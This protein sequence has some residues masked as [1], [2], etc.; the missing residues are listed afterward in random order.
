MAPKRKRA[1]A[2]ECME[3]QDTLDLISVL[4]KTSTSHD[5]QQRHTV[6]K[7]AC[8]LWDFFSAELRRAVVNADDRPL[9]HYYSCDGTPMRTHHRNRSTVKDIVVR[10]D[11]KATHEFLAQVVFLRY[12]DA[13][14]LCVDRVAFAPPLP[15]T[16]G[17]SA[18]AHFS[19]S[20]EFMSSV[21]A[22]GHK[23]ILVHQYCFDRALSSAMTRLLQQ[24]H[25]LE[26]PLYGASA[27]ESKYLARLE[28]VEG[29]GCSLHDAH[30]SL[31][32][33]MSF[34]RLGPDVMKNVWVVFASLRNSFD[35]ILL[36]LPQ[37]LVVHVAWTPRDQL[38]TPD[39]LSVLWQALQLDEEIVELLAQD[40]QLWWDRDATMLR[41]AE[42]WKCRP[43]A[44]QEL[45]A[46]LQAVWQFKKFSDSRWITIGC[47]CRTLTAAILTGLASLVDRIRTHTIG[48]ELHINGWT[49]LGKEETRFVVLSSM[50]AYVSDRALT[51]IFKDTRVA[52]RA[53]EISAEV[54]DSLERMEKLDEHV[55][56]SLALCH[57]PEWRVKGFAV[58]GEALSAAHASAG[59]FHWKCLR[60]TEQLPWTLGRGDVGANLVALKAG[61]KPA[62][63][64]ARKIW[65]LLQAGHSREQLETGVRLLMDAPWATSAT[66]QAHAMGA[67]VKRLHHELGHKAIIS[68][69][70]V[71]GFRKMFPKVSDHDAQMLKLRDDLV[72]N[73]A[74]VPSRCSARHML[75]GDAVQTAMA[76]ERPGGRPAGRKQRRIMKAHSGFF[77]KLSEEQRQGYEMA[78]EIHAREK[79]EQWSQEREDTLDR[80][81]EVRKKQAKEM[82]RRKPLTL[83]SCRLDAA[84]VQ[85][86]HNSWT[87]AHTSTESIRDRVAKLCEAP[88]WISQ[89][90]YEEM[91]A[92]PYHELD[93]MYNRAAQRPRWLA[94]VVAHR[95][96]FAN[97]VWVLQKGIT[98]EYY[99]FLLAQQ[100][101]HQILFIPLTRLDPAD[102]ERACGSVDEDVQLL[103]DYKWDLEVGQWRDWSSL[104][105]GAGCPV[106]VITQCRHIGNGEVVGMGDPPL[107]EDFLADLDPIPVTEPA[108]KKPKT[109][110]YK[111]KLTKSTIA[112]CPLIEED[113]HDAGIPLDAVAEEE[114]EEEETLD[115]LGMRLP[116]REFTDAE[117]VALWTRLEE[118][119]AE[120]DGL[121]YGKL[122]AGAFKVTFTKGE[123]TKKK[124]GRDFDF[125][126]AYAVN[127][128]SKQ[129]CTRYRMQDSARFAT[130]QYG[131]REATILAQGWCSRMDHFLSIYTT[132]EDPD[133]TF[134]AADTA[135]WDPPP[136]WQATYD[137]VPDRAKARV[138]EL[139]AK[140]PTRR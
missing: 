88:D 112:K 36:H 82:E 60:A 122:S 87:S 92:Q 140:E 85:R 22:M 83:S 7:L 106:R 41:V 130:G 10:R 28:W 26:A 75:F 84:G 17:K 32:W 76:M 34:E 6:Q 29:A 118:K 24:H 78:A 44:M 109:E 53:D 134:I 123:F 55:W 96:E 71:G 94:Q 46:A 73:A 49:K 110:G 27:T 19:A 93:W 51:M 119:R 67:L 86:L 47:S 57:K 68:R 20:L 132:S 127:K 135:S 107:L 62:Q 43:D 59:Y 133:Y 54:Q 37:W 4:G 90:R 128:P 13:P 39:K 99:K 3:G 120:W 104:G 11:G 65:E 74:H 9:L 56:E 102:E 116:D 16:H 15:M 2:A 115:V 137:A 72:A 124:T 40:L 69:A 30:N 45:S 100:N 23:G 70:M 105:F 138:T 136:H 64:T 33:G 52:Q 108:P 14:N 48:R 114:L 35:L 21:R 131:E 25:Q 79:E 63:P 89:P 77:G 113:L 91:S 58:R 1:V 98:D 8:G 81:V 111:Y 139:F 12:E 61:P 5:D 126:L 103:W 80:M 18:L 121:K 50:A 117:K 31:K 38:P 101:P 95:Q 42:D 129:W 97:T 125:C 66:E